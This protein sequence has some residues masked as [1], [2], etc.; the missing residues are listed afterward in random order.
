VDGDHC[1][2]LAELDDDALDAAQVSHLGCWSGPSAISFGCNGKPT[3]ISGPYDDTDHVLRTLERAV[4]R[5]GFG[6]TVGV[7]LGQL[8][9]A[10]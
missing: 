5:E 10:G 1:C 8:P 3:Y 6:Y 4:G 2:V 9:F 7:D